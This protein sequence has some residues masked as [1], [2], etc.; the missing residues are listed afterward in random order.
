MELTFSKDKRLK[1]RRKIETNICL[2]L[3]DPLVSDENKV[4]KQSNQIF[5]CTNL[6][7]FIRMQNKQE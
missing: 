7:E 4:K 6:D 2:P 5:S 3:Y 1:L